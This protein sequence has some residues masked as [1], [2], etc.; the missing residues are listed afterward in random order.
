MSVGRATRLASSCVR[1][2]GAAWQRSLSSE[3]KQ[4]GWLSMQL[5]MGVV[6]AGR[7]MARLA[8]CC[9]QRDASAVVSSGDARTMCIAHRGSAASAAARGR[10][11]SSAAAACQRPANRLAAGSTAAAAHSARAHPVIGSRECAKCALAPTS[12]NVATI[13][14]ESTF[15]ARGCFH[16]LVRRVASALTLSGDD[17]ASG[18]R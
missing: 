6:P 1:A 5:K 14:D 10:C 11:G 13:G 18:R 4:S 2:T 15:V 12:G 8:S 7:A 17:R 3:S 16:A 9:R